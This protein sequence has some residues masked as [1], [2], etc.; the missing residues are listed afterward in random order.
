MVTNGICTLANDVVYD[1]WVALLNSIEVNA[2]GLPICVY[3]Y[4]DRL[5]RIAAEIAQRPHVQLYQDL[6][7]IYRWDQFF[8]AVWDCHP[9]AK[10][11]WQKLGSSEYHRFGTHRRFCAF[12]GPFDRFLYLDADTLLLKNVDFI[13]RKLDEFDWVIYDFQHKDPSHVY[14]VA[15]AKLPE[16]FPP[17]RIQSEIFCSGLYATRRDIFDS[18]QLDFLLQQLASGEAEILYPM[19]ADQPILNYMVM[20]SNLKVCNLALQLPKTEV[21]GCCV[22][23]P[24]FEQRDNVLY[25]RGVPLTYLHYIG[26]SSSAFTQLCQGKNWSFPYHELF[27]YYRYLHALDQRPLFKGKAKPYN[28]PPNLFQRALRKFKLTRQ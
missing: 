5:D 14:A 28:A 9:T 22:T 23:S 27:L 18:D 6:A 4:D 7:S 13:F 8:K 11:L 25:D 2:P 19:A 10:A 17:E 15:S 21:T 12:D 16:V 24:H 3:P 26:I 1:Q 20:R